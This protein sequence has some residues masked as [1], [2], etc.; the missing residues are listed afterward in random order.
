MTIQWETFICVPPTI[1]FPAT[2]LPPVLGETVIDFW[3]K[4]GEAQFGNG[5]HV[6]L[7]KWLKLFSAT[8][9]S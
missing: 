1:I 3:S 5:Q 7:D 4:G 9:S 2:R 6:A 8:V